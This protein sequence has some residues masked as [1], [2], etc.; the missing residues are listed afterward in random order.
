M[1]IYENIQNAR[2]CDFDKA[3]YSCGIELVGRKVS[4]DI[5]KEFKTWDSLKSSSETEIAN[6]KKL[7]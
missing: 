4:K 2:N 3:I 7:Q 5:A 1:S 6:R